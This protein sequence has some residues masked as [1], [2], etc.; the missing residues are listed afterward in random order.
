[1]DPEFGAPPIQANE[2]LL[3]PIYGV[4]KQL[5]VPVFLMSGPTT[6]NLEFDN[7]VAAGKVAWTFSGLPSSATTVFIRM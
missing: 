1:M 3:Y 4:C 2:P 6:P 7:P 5:D